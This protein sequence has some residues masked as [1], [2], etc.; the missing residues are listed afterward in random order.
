M[1]KRVQSPSSIN[2]YKQ[3]PRKYFYQYIKGYETIP[4]IHQ[5]R[6]SVTHDVLEKF[7]DW[8]ISSVKE[9]NFPLQTKLHLQFLLIQEWKKAENEFKKVDLSPDQKKFYFE[10]TLLMLLNWADH[11][12][13]DIKK[14]DLPLTVA[15]SQLTP[16]RE[17]EYSSTTLN[18]HGFVDA[19]HRLGEKVRIVD[20]KTNATLEIN[21]E[22]KLQLAIYSLLYQEKYNQTPS[23]VG[24]FFLRHKLKLM[25]VDEELLAFAR[26]EIELIHQKTESEDIAYYPQNIS[27][28]CKWSSGRC[29]FFE[30]CKPDLSQ[31]KNGHH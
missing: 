16:E 17:K 24:I 27:G 21:E 12:I 23:E 10:E 20:Y 7:F 1:A 22:Q 2:T 3:C 28:L 4:N 31:K 19:V 6:G 8:D 26:K 30:F 14:T 25:K 9:E 11:F 13:E 18:V 5:V 15:F 29:D